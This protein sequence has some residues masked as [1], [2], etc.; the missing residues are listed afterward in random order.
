METIYPRVGEDLLELGKRCGAVYVCPKKNGKRTGPLVAYAGKDSQ[1][2]NLVGDIFF[3]FAKI[4][5]HPKVVA[6]FAEAA[7]HKISERGLLSSF[8]TVCGVPHGGRTFGHALAL[9]AGK[10]FVYADKVPKPTAPGKKQEYAWDM[11]R[12]TLEKGECMAI[13]EDVFNNFQNTS[14]T[15]DAVS[16]TGARIVALIGALNR[17]PF[18]DDLYS[19]VTGTYV[20]RSLPVVAAIRQPYPEFQQDDPEVAADIAVGNVEFEVKKNWP[21]L[22]QAMRSV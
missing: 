13:V 3:N 9:A 11:S 15:L 4:E 17:S 2:R 1:G 10:R 14:H 18:C 19:P 16:A 5:E 7:V 8:D 21:R 20:G 6:A 22:Q 12:F